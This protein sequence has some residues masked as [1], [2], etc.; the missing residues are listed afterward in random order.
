MPKESIEYFGSRF[1]HLYRFAD[2]SK[3][4][5]YFITT[6]FAGQYSPSKID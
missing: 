2:L 1:G 3:M 5:N 6:V 4:I